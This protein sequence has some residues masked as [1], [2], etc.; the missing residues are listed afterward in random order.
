[1]FH[2]TP[3]H[4]NVMTGL[5]VMVGTVPLWRSSMEGLK[6]SKLG[7]KRNTLKDT[8]I[9]QQV[10]TC[11]TFFPEFKYTYQFFRLVKTGRVSRLPC[12]TGLY[13][14]QLALWT[15][16]FST[17]VLNFQGLLGYSWTVIAIFKLLSTS[18]KQH[19]TTKHG[20]RPMRATLEPTPTPGC[21]RQ[22]WRRQHAL[23]RGSGGWTTQLRSR[24]SECCWGYI[25]VVWGFLK[26]QIIH[27]NWVLFMNH[28]AIGVPAFMH[29]WNPIIPYIYI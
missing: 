7:S 19:E 24:H 1:M 22:T 2:F 28:P 21:I 14:T 5:K 4:C 11:N 9:K 16:P 20:P 29:L 13:H 23:A 10:N 25:H 12:F 17:H 27:F 18:W 8:C 6:L 26:S 15:S 3:V